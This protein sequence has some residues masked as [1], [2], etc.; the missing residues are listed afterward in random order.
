MDKDN[1]V[2]ESS[3]TDSPKASELEYRSFVEEP[4]EDDGENRKPTERN[5]IIATSLLVTKSMIGSGLLYVP[6]HFKTLGIIFR[7]RSKCS[8]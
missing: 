5:S 3:G 4:G 1:E 7:N 2:Q 8:F 6:Y